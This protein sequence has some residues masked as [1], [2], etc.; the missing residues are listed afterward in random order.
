MMGIPYVM[1]S[2]GG[3]D[4]GNFSWKFNMA[5]NHHWPEGYFIG[6]YK[7]SRIKH[8]FTSLFERFSSEPTLHFLQPYIPYNVARIIYT[9]S[10][11]PDPKPKGNQL[12]LVV[13][14]YSWS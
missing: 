13:S 4:T 8:N 5:T 9:L 10:Y 1:G 12:Y 2:L 6:H 14:S 3:I 11:K 7:D